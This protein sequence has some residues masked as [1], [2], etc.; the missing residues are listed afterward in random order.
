[1][2]LLNERARVRG[3]IATARKLAERGDLHMATIAELDPETATAAD[4]GMSPMSCD[5]CGAAETWDIVQVGEE[6]PWEESST[7]YV[8]VACL[9]KAVA[10]VESEAPPAA[11]IVDPVRLAI[12]VAIR[13]HE[14]QVD[15]AERPY[16]D[17]PLRVM[18]RVAADDVEG[19]VVAVLHDVLEDS[20]ITAQDL[21]QMGFSERIITA[22]ERLTH[23]RD[24]PYEE[25]LRR[26]A[27]DELTRRVKLADIAD[28]ADEGRLT[29]L[30][31]AEAARL[32]EKYARARAVLEGEA[33]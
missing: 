20:E 30:S 1:M 28:N 22:L 25:Y 27:A 29:L 3:V 7:A 24:E 4:L 8:C 9:Q 10:L 18:E 12:T 17:H 19:R 11:P 15:K 33:P 14:Y 13:A 26:V 6:P 23:R 31:Q 2:K 16:I 5:E 32:R 21:R